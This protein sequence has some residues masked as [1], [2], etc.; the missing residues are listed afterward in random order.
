[1]AV[2]TLAPD[3]YLTIFDNVGVIAPG[4]KINSYLS[5]TSTPSP[6][7]SDAALSAPQNPAV[8]DSS[9]RVT[10]Y[11]DP[12]IGNYKFI[13][14]KSDG[15]ALRTADPVAAVNTSSGLGVQF[16]FGGESSTPVTQTSYNS[17]STFDKLQPGTAAF[18]KDSASLTG[19][20]V[21]QATGVVV[22][23]TMSV[24]IMDLSSGTPD[25][26]IATAASITST[27]G[28]MA[29]SGTIT[30]ATPGTPHTYGIKTLITAGGTG[31]VWGIS[32]VRTA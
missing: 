22:S 3:P 1:M 20:Y 27:T 10:V 4:A 30:F 28:Q 31:F 23:G 17:G 7:Y 18:V 12:A 32:L 21:I 8:A 2:G 9:G 29:Q 24:A 25:T 5:G 16:V 15:S 19:T 11:L 6:T 13:I 14:T 26:P